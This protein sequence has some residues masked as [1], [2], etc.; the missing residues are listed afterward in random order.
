MQPFQISGKA[1]VPETYQ[2]SLCCQ[3]LLQY[4]SK[5]EVVLAELNLS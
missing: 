2:T 5:G 3:D 4:M 1:G